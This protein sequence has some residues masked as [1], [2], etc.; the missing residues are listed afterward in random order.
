MLSSTNPNWESIETRQYII[1]DNPTFGKI[2]L[3]PVGMSQISS[4]NFEKNLKV[5][6]TV[7]K[8]DPLGYFLFGGS[9]YMMILEKG[10]KLDITIPKTDG[11]YYDYVLMGEKYGKLTKE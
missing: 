11:E 2:A 5:G 3:V 9:D 6:D 1:I 10:V 7:K 4:V 8:G